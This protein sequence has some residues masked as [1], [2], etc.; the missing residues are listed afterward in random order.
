MTN[1][2]KWQPRDQRAVDAIENIRFCLDRGLLVWRKTSLGD[3]FREA[4]DSLQALEWLVEAARLIRAYDQAGGADWWK[5]H[6]DL[7][8][9]LERVGCERELDGAAE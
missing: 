2:G 1:S 5:A 4:T 8:A 6:A 7:Y 3:C 9:A